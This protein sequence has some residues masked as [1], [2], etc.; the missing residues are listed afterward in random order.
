MDIQRMASIFRQWR[1]R[2]GIVLATMLVLSLLLS[3]IAL[4]SPLQD[5]AI[6]WWTVDGGGGTFSTGGDYSLGGTVGQTDGGVL[7]GGEY[8]LDG[9]FWGGA[10]ARY[11]VFLPLVLRN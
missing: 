11:T 5:Y 8:R 4:A 10:T 6:S 7:E 9:G 1:W 2:E 3:T